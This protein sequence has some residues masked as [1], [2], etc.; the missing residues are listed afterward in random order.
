[1][2]RRSNRKGRERDAERRYAHAAATAT[3]ER[4]RRRDAEQAR[5]E[6]L[7]RADYLDR[8]LRRL[9]EIHEGTVGFLTPAEYQQIGATQDGSS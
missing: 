6:A 5:D 2:S 4:L 8:Q 1:M 7:D 3:A 9:N